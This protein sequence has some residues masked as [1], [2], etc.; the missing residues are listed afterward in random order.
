MTYSW[1]I[2]KVKVVATDTITSV[3]ENYLE[4]NIYPNPTDNILTINAEEE[5]QNISIYNILSVKMMEMVINNKE[6]VIDLTNFESGMYFIEII[7]KDEKS[8]KTFIKK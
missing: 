4:T 3:N 5:I 1:F 6:A 7:G 8:I 2:D